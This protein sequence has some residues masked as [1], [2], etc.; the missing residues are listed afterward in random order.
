MRLNE[1]RHFAVFEIADANAAP[2]ARVRF[3]IR[4]RVSSVNN[5]VLTDGE[6]AAA[7]EVIVFADEFSLIGEDHDAMVMSIGDD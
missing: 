5:V 3:G 7:A 6:T 2:P 4:F 1:Y